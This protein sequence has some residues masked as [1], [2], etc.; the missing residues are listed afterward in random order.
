M[1]QLCHHL[2]YVTVD[3]SHAIRSVRMACG[4]NNEQSVSIKL[5]TLHGGSGGIGPNADITIKE[6]AENK[7][8]GKIDLPG[9]L[10]LEIS[11]DTIHVP[12]EK[13]RRATTRYRHHEDQT[14]PTPVSYTHLTLPTK[15]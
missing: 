2:C 11:T 10:V 15:A 6:D 5:P 9:R 14:H 3:W 4:I 7:S 8:G 12:R 1:S 13:W